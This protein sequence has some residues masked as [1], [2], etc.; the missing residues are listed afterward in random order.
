M[1]LVWNFL[2]SVFVDEFSSPSRKEFFSAVLIMA[3]S[4]AL[5]KSCIPPQVLIWRLRIFC[6]L[7]SGRFSPSHNNTSLQKPICIKIINQLKYRNSL[8]YPNDL[9]FLLLI[10]LR[11]NRIYK[12]T[13]S[14]LKK[15]LFS[16]NVTI[17][18]IHLKIIASRD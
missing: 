5:Q 9:K 11:F 1:D 13:S 6:C 18:K 7:L 3:S 15:S 14:A 4:V 17:N 10:H 16:Q 8:C 2:V 12:L